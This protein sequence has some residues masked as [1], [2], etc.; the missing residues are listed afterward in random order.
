[1]YRNKEIIN[2]QYSKWYFGMSEEAK[3]GKIKANEDT[4]KNKSERISN[5]L[6]LWIW[7]KYELNKI[8]DL[9]TVNRCKNNRFCPN[10]RILDISKFIHKFKDIIIEYMQKDYH[11]YML[12]LTI[13]NVKGEELEQT[14][15]TLS[16]R[17]LTLTRRYKSTCKKQHSI[18]IDGGVRVLE[19]THNSSV[20]TYHPHYHCMVMV[21]DGV[22]AEL[23]QKN[24]K[25]RYSRKRKSVNMKS[26]LDLEISRYWTLIY[27]G[28]SVSKKALRE[29]DDKD[30]YECDFCELDEK[31][32]Y[33]VFKYT[34][35]DVD[36]DAY[37]TFVTLELALRYKRLRQG[38][39]LLYNVQCEDIEE[40]EY[41]ELQLMYQ[42]EPELMYMQ[43]M[44]ELYT[45]YESY[46]KVSR[47]NM[48]IDENVQK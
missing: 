30:I 12:T 40:G 41:Q 47:F 8:L 22:P 19:I 33:E 18:D 36:V 16:K 21:K 29:L 37:K 15:R 34:F 42:E 24:I 44:R 32:F 11:M 28:K 26:V 35:K 4:C 3:A 25:G 6:N 7:D 1:M 48:E 17:F 46:K 9:Q 13:P 45:T 14:L 39:G 27:Q 5:C 20:D 10:C 43:D 23:L 31:G 2:R 38:F